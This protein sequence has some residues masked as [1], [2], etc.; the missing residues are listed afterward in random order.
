LLANGEVVAMRTRQHWTAIIR[1]ILYPI[2]IVIAVL[3]IFFFIAGVGSDGFVG[4]V[5]SVLTAV[6]GGLIVAILWSGWSSGAGRPRTTS[7]RTGV[8]ASR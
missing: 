1:D 4:T 6:L 5:K 2:L 8:L 7:S 3:V